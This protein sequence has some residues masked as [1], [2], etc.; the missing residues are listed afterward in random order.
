MKDIKLKKKQFFKTVNLLS[1]FF[2]S[3]NFE[4]SST[5]DFL[6]DFFF[7]LFFVLW[8]FK[9][10]NIEKEGNKNSFLFSKNFISTKNGT[11]GNYYFPSFLMMMMKY[12]CLPHHQ[13]SKRRQ[14][15]EEGR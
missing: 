1:I 12:P 7:C 9:K 3:K 6:I 15:Q 11:Q 13:Q 10:K 4:N 8:K 2:F 14:Q 5:F